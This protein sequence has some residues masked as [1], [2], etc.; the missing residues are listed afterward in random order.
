MSKIFS[1]VLYLKAE[2]NKR[3]RKIQEL[4]YFCETSKKYLDG[5]IYC[6]DLKRKIIYRKCKKKLYLFMRNK[7]LL[8]IHSRNKKSS[9]G[10]KGF[11]NKFFDRRYK[12]I[13]RRDKKLFHGDI[14]LSG[15]INEDIKIFDYKKRELLTI[16]KT[17]ERAN[18][19]IE[20]RTRFSAQGFKTL[21]FVID[22]IGDTT[23]LREPLLITKDYDHNSIFQRIIENYINHQNVLE[24]TFPYKN[25]L[26]DEY[27]YCFFDELKRLNIEQES[28][29]LNSLKKGYYSVQ[30][31]HGD[32]YY[33]NYIFDGKDYYYIDFEFVD[34]HIFFYDIFFYIFME[35]YR[36]GNEILWQSVVRGNFNK[37]LN[38]LFTANK[39]LFDKNDIKL[40]LTYTIFEYYESRIPADVETMLRKLFSRDY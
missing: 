26:D 31:S 40:Y 11:I 13:I 12:F 18:K 9:N 29:F 2:S 24:S 27:I 6:L 39:F 28:T 36:F 16:F 15:T 35:I 21:H 1:V 32:F 38:S 23:L 4:N 19:I 34:I 30:L 14:A 3:K 33:F 10:L 37:Q 20:N 5:G 8:E 25:R 22:R 17:H 7:T